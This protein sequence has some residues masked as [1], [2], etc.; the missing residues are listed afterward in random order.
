MSLHEN[1]S[2]LLEL[3]DQ[4][5][6]DECLRLLDRARDEALDLLLT[7]HQR[8]RKQ[9]HAII[10]SERGR[11][12]NRVAAARAELETKRRLHR[13]QLGSVI[14]EAAHRRLPER[15]AERWADPQSRAVWIRNAVTF[16]LQRLPAGRWRVRHAAC[17]RA[18][19]HDVL[20]QT[21]NR[22]RAQA[23]ELVADSGIDAGLVI[24]CGG[25]RLDASVQGLL[26]DS[27]AYQARLLALMEDGDET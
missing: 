24:E 21:L 12:R 14:L 11:L 5:R 23:P 27:A 2:R 1:E 18:A 15:L 9:V 13:H 17:F 8:A 6:D 4:W 3:V 20:L 26:A 25:V 19:D 22:H 7:T 10:Q 16:A